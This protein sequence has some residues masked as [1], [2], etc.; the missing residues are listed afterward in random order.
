[1]WITQDAA[2]ALP[3]DEPEDPDE[4]DDPEELDDDE[5]EDAAADVVDAGLADEPLSLD[6]DSLDFDSLAFDSAPVVAGF[7]PL[8]SALLSLR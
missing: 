1:M 8:S 4:P 3:D 2:A 5:P 6:F 7:L